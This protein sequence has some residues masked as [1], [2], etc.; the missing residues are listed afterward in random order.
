MSITNY[1]NFSALQL[2]LQN[3]LFFDHFFDQAKQ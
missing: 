1:I 3:H 2:L